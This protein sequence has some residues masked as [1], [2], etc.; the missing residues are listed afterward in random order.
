MNY[1]NCFI[2]LVNV[3]CILSKKKI[4]KKFQHENITKTI[5]QNNLEELSNQYTKKM[6]SEIEKQVYK[7]RIK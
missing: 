2:I 1:Y 6:I 4:Y 5:K 3:L 7:K